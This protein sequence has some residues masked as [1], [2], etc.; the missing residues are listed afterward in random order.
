MSESTNT[1]AHT[2]R[3]IKGKL[4][5]PADEV[6]FWSRVDK[7][8]PIPNQSFAHYKGL[9]CCW[10]WAAGRA[11]GGY[12]QFYVAGNTVRAHRVAFILGSGL[13]T[14]EANCVM[15]ACDNP[16]CVNPNHLRAGSFRDNNND[17]ASK[18]RSVHV[19]GCG[20]YSHLHPERCARG[21]QHG[22]SKLKEPQVRTIR[23]AH[24]NGLKQ[25]EI[26][27]LVGVSRQS[28]GHILRG[29]IWKHVGCANKETESN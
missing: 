29:E 3:T 23:I 24:A 9:D 20:H 11:R 22:N 18:G 7:N 1:H 6:R 28:I 19:R 10:V 16:L 27:A 12:G 15:H 8:G 2:T 14:A 13:L 25:R 26:A 5:T 17:R 4:I 21:E